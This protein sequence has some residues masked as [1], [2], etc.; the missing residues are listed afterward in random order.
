[1]FSNHPRGPLRFLL[2]PFSLLYWLGIGMRNWLYDRNILRSSAFGLPLICVGNLS[3]GGTGKS[4]MVEFLVQRLNERFRVATLSRGYKRKTR[5]YAL[6]NDSTTALEIGDEP[7]QFHLK[8]PGVPVAVGESRQEAIAQLLHD[9]PETELIILDD[10]FQHRQVRAGLNILL[11]E[12]QRLYTRDFYLPA[13]TLRDQKKS[14]GRAQVLV[15]TKC[16]PALSREESMAIREELSPAKEQEIFF[17]TLVYGEIT[18]II[19]RDKLPAGK[20]TSVLLVTGIA[21]PLPLQQFVRSVAERMETVRY[22][23]HHIYTIDDLKDIRSRFAELEGNKII[24]TTEKDAVRLYKFENELKELPLYVIPVKHHFLF[25]EEE[26]FLRKVCGYVEKNK[27]DKQ[28][29]NQ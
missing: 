17:T 4:P 24:L 29:N 3:V 23:D 26:K 9:R 13:G 2:L 10:A 12:K 15:V 22:S 27:L 25:G 8:F 21:N 5:G 11:T 19:D 7:M 28:D 16:E 20:L 1:M 6:A 18:H 14:A